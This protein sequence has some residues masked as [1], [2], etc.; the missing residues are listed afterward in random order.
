MPSS[1]T[2]PPRS[3]T[4]SLH[5]ALPISMI[6]LMNSSDRSTLESSSDPETTLPV[7]SVPAVPMT[8]APLLGPSIYMFPPR[9]IRPC[10]LLKVATAR[11]EEHTSELQSRPHLVCRL[12]LPTH[13]AASLFPYTTLF[14]SR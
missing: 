13:L 4:L 5:D 12:L 8:A 6:R 1:A 7:P 11:S 10:V 3:F 9:S 2:H 14:R